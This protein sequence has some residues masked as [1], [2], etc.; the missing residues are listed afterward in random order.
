MGARSNHEMGHAR[1]TSVPPPSRT[2]DERRP[3]VH[4]VISPQPDPIPPPQPPSPR[5]DPQ[6]PLPD[7]TPD[8][9]S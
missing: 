2:T 6:P 8:L 1:T 9:P 7:P 5:P 4:D 3:T